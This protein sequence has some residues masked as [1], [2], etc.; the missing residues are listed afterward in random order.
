VTVRT[1]AVDLIARVQGYVGGLATAAASTRTLVGEID[2][3]GRTSPERFSR[4]IG[5]MTVA[6]GAM[7]ALAG[8]AVHVGTE[9]DKQMSAVGAAAEATGSDLQK[10]RDTALAA[11]S[12]TAYSATAAAEAEEELAKA[13]VRTTDIIA[14]GLAG[15]LSLASAGQMQVGE[16]AEIAATAM[17]QFGLSGKDLP[18][19]ADLLAAGAN[20]AQGEVHH[21]GMA[22]RQSGLVAAQFGLS[23]EE[24][25]GTLAAFAS[26]GL[27]GSDSGTSL[28]TMLL[29]LANPSDEAAA[30]MRQLGINAYDASGQF[31]G[32][33]DLAGQLRSG[34]AGLTQAQRDQTLAMIFGTDAV[35]AANVLYKLGADGVHEWKES[36]N[37]AGYAAEMA[38]EKMD[39][40]AGDLQK[41][42]GHLTT[43][44]ITS[45]EGANGG[46]RAIVQATTNMVNTLASAP[47]AVTSAGVV[48]AGIGGIAL[49]ASAGVLKLR[50]SIAQATASMAA[51]GPVGARFSGVLDKT[52]VYAGRAMAAMVAMQIAFAAAGDSA[53]PQVNALA[54]SL[55]DYGVSG[56]AAGEASKTFGDGLEN[57]K[58]DLGTLDTGRWTSFSNGFAGTVEGLTGMGNVMDQ[59][60][61]HAKERLSGID[62]ALASLV[63]SGKA[64]QA[65]AAFDRLRKVAD[66][67]GISLNEL[68]K[69][70]PQYGAALDD[71]ATGNKSAAQAASEN[72]TSQSRLAK[73][74]ADAVEKAG[75]FKEAF[76][77]LKGSMIS[78]LDTSMA[79]EQALDDL[80]ESLNKNGNQWD[81]NTAAGRDN[82]KAVEDVIIKARDA[83]QAKY[84]ETGSVS[85]ATAVYSGYIDRLRATAGQSGSLRAEVDA[86]IA[87][88]GSLPPAV[89]T[90]VYAFGLDEVLA[91]ASS[92]FTHLKFLN[93]MRVDTYIATHSTTYHE[94]VHVGVP[95]AGGTLLRRWGGITEHA[96]S[97]LLNAGVFPAGSQPLY[98]FAE[99]ATGGE[100]FI[101]RHGD[102]TR[103]RGIA[104]R[105]VRDWLGG[106]V[107]WGRSGSSGAGGS[108]GGTTVVNNITI[109][110]NVP[111]VANPVEVGREIVRVV[112]QYQ[113]A[114][115]G[116]VTV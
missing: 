19:V 8:Y 84:A 116:A 102:M 23:I 18:H 89:A 59:S 104:E 6:G 60:L 106:D 55:A 101:P 111:A 69:A 31:V 108:G 81:I 109:P 22:L 82:T 52:A 40:L 49:L 41:L 66:D 1:V 63:S 9:F 67:Q 7:L 2:T 113:Q 95:G 58:Y 11:G 90:R 43:L 72:A 37:E 114:S 24:T 54:K 34:L 50:S 68:M 16:A 110:V 27:I 33:E 76:D 87:K 75:S 15:A 47:S 4:L 53:S 12:T 29:K 45:Q 46:L 26:A 44:A 93:G 79:A 35:R 73:T 25:T 13:G 14:G 28:K 57:L 64:D 96:A 32:L 5:P 3:L 20:K 74:M 80:S 91:Q 10:L 21:L 30:A 115:T 70:L 103:S 107:Q 88:Y 17:N 71:S 51:A 39:N 56:K 48:I 92:L 99:P 97:G 83:A 36:V 78:I 105:V 42:K 86:L 77:A 62:E 98:A 112:R 85:E 100:A 65:K 61:V 94:D 38:R